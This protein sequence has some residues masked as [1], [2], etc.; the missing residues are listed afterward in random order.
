MKKVPLQTFKTFDAGGARRPA[1]SAARAGEFPA[2][3]VSGTAY[4]FRR[5]IRAEVIFMVPQ[6]SMHDGEDEMIPRVLFSSPSHG[7]RGRARAAA[8]LTKVFGSFL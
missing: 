6:R 8:D 4:N 3:H 2:S 1:V 7:S 5:M